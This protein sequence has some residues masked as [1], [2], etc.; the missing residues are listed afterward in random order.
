M[1]NKIIVFFLLIFFPLVVFAASNTS[2][3]EYHLGKFKEASAGLNNLANKNNKNALYFLGLMS[4]NGYGEAQ[5]LEKGLSYISRA[6]K[7]GNLSAQ[8]FMG[9]YALQKQ[10]NAE[11]A[12]YWFK[13]AS[14]QG[15]TTAEM[16]CAA[17]YL[18]GYGVKRNPEKAKIFYINAAKS[19]NPIAQYTIAKRFIDSKYKTNKKLGLIWLN[20]AVAQ[21]DPNA[22]FELGRMYFEGYQVEK[23]KSEG[24]RLIETSLKQN[25]PK[26][27][28][29]M[30]KYYQNLG[31]VDNIS[32]AIKLYKDSFQKG[33]FD[34]QFQLGMLYLFTNTDVRNEKEGYLLILKTAMDGNQQAQ[35]QLA[36]MY[37]EGIYVEKNSTLAEQ[38][39]KKSKRNQWRKFSP[40]E[41][42]QL[43]MQW[44]SNGKHK[45][46][47][48]KNY[49]LTGI[50]S[51]WQNKKTLS[52]GSYNSSPVLTEI[53]RQ[54]I[55]TH[56]FTM[57]KPNEI[58]IQQF[59]N[60]MGQ[61]NYQRKLPYL[62]IPHYQLP[63][64][65]KPQL[66]FKKLSNEAQYGYAK[67]Q[68][69]L[70]QMYEQGIGTKKNM[71]EAIYWYERATDQKYLKAE[72]NMGL[73]YLEGNGVKKN[74]KLALYWLEKAAFKGSA[75]SQY[76]LAL[77]HEF[78]LGEKG[79]KNYIPENLEYAN[80]M[81]NLAASNGYGEAEF[82]LAELY[83]SGLINEGKTVQS[84]RRLNQIVLALYQKAAK[85]GV[86]SAQIALAYYY[87]K[88]EVS[89]KKKEW[90][91][92]IADQEAQKGNQAAQLILGIMYDRGI[93]TSQNKKKALQWYQ[94]LVD[95]NNPVADFILGTYYYLGETIRQN[96]QKAIQ[97]LTKAADEDIP[98]ATYNL[99]ILEKNNNGDFLTLLKK[100]AS[101]NY[102]KASLLLADYYLLNTNDS[103]DLKT[104]ADIYQE[105]GRM[106]YDKAQLK[107]GYMYE[108][109]IYVKQNYKDAE[110]WYVK[111]AEQNNTI[112]QY[113]LANMYLAGKLGSP[114]I[115]KAWA[116]Y[117]KA[118]KLGFTPAKVALGF[119]NEQIDHNYQKAFNWYH[120]A[121]D[122][123]N[124]QAQF[125]LALMY[126]Y[127]KG[128]NIDH[129]KA[130][131]WFSKAAAQGVSPQVYPQVVDAE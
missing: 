100:A 13:K 66:L 6:G 63:K 99:A 116:W 50:L 109:G 102:H 56:V 30:A 70:G 3:Y 79:D 35:K 107:L 53:N 23:N 46:L 110:K 25:N 113:L 36:K 42:K 80:G 29:F 54:Q 43:A 128:V 94:K 73:L 77:I 106:G 93:G 65:I 59:I 126:E 26:A 41:A 28:L 123:N 12:F 89:K 115:P 105:L 40:E 88:P 95:A 17:A 58:N 47:N 69:Q 32:K 119:M 82:N 67:S 122:E 75:Y 71:K 84:Q 127:G 86:K 108:N 49:R 19:G 9:K 60:V 131:K 74:Y 64:N 81:Y 5:N 85:R 11:K 78:G 111:A 14:D 87:A 104:A 101:L 68:F 45:D 33:N 76:L 61:L 55:F 98:Y 90:A 83:V 15:N 51:D 121:A 97:L 39:L 31:G 129:K 44:L 124:P 10:N 48:I 96:H 21:K 92:N 91:F 1:K 16:Y 7:L 114:M 125:N 34:A 22:Q 38:W 117:Q 24:L 37:E 62:F 2:F 120:Q 118:A 4:I 112:A 20:K 18:F 8:M 103:Y 72:Y 52:Q 130:S 27:E 57:T